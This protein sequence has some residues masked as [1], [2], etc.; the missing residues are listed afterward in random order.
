MRNNQLKV[1]LINY[2]LICLFVVFQYSSSD[3]L[4]QVTQEGCKTCNTSNVMKM[5][6]N[7]N[8]TITL[9]KPGPWYFISGNK[10][11]CLGG[12]KLQ[13]NV[14]NNQAY[15]PASAP[16]PPSGSNQGA[17]LP[18]PSSKSNLPTSTGVTNG[19]RHTLIVSFA[20]GFMA[21]VLLVVKN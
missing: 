12:M 20:L 9:S 4:N 21:T 10:L 17:S 3:T 15:S 5:Y 6:T 1:R 13:V 8:T 18:Q 16:L 7:G 14:E 19:G 2:A 11:Y